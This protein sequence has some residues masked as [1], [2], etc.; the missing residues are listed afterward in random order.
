MGS[1]ACCGGR[2][3]SGINRHEFGPGHRHEQLIVTA[4]AF[5]QVLAQRLGAFRLQPGRQARTGQDGYRQIGGQLLNT[6]S[7][8]DRLAQR[9]MR[10]APRRPERPDD[11][12][13]GFQPD[14]Q[15][16]RLQRTAI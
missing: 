5:Q 14:P 8:A 10:T 13:T 1:I 16:Q 9:R 6:R 3:P 12:R 11:S 7:D 2:G 4:K 15:R